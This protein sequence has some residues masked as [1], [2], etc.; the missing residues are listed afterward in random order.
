MTVRQTQDPDDF[1]PEP[2][3]LDLREYWLIVRRRWRLVAVI[4]VIGAMAGAGYAYGAGPTYAATAQVVVTPVTQGPLN[5]AGQVSTQVNMSTEQ[6]VAQ[7]PPVVQQA[8]AGLHVRPAKLEAAAGKRL[9]VTVPAST[10][11]TSNVLQIT[12]KAASPQAAQTGADAFASSYL[13]FRHH[14]LA[15]QIA[16]YRS[17]LNTQVASLQS[18][19]AML[20]T[21]LGTASGSSRHQALTIRLSELTSQ[22]TT[23]DDQLATLATYNDAGGQ[24]IGAARPG[25][26]SGLGHSALLILGALIGLM[27]GLALAFTREVFDDRIRDTAQ[28]ESKLG[29]PTLAVLST[30]ESRAEN[31]DGAR[32]QAP[33]IASAATPDSRAA[34]GFRALRATLVATAS[35]NELRTLLLVAADPSISSGRIAAELGVALAES[36]RR[37]LLVAADL[38]GSVIP[39]IFDVPN[40]TGLADLLISG[41]DPQVLTRH[42]KQAAGAP[43]SA[44]VVKRLA[45]LPSGPQLPHAFSILDSRAMLD[46]LQSQRDSYEFVLLDSP[47]ATVADVFA[48]A[49]HVDGVIVLARE[50]RTN[51]R[52]VEDLRRRLDQVGAPVIG[53]VLIGKGKTGRHRHRSGSQP[54]I[55]SLSMAAPERRDAPGPRDAGE[56]REVGQ[57]ARMPAPP[58]TRPMPLIPA[59]DAPPRASGRAVKRSL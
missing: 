23:A 50:A 14:E 6:A 31:G 12:W 17:S 34:E 22:A 48:L 8:A 39:P 18:Q 45:V 54:A 59:D 13:S 37:V 38:R 51:G 11:T 44:T 32:G 41:G 21:E 36:G 25:K 28:L 7:S 56:R 52:A 46:V 20:T 2:R 29:A 16:S 5:S 47:P 10:L 26:P 43:L 40:T 19:I 42:P 53:G 55:A 15:N 49:S 35:R 9:T 1:A 3:S 33:A 30:A 4:T 27:A 57:A 24:F 58:A